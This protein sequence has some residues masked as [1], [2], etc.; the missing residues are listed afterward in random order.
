MAFCEDCQCPREAVT[1][2]I[3]VGET[4]TARRWRFT[5]HNRTATFSRRILVEDLC[6]GSGKLV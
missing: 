4:G 1:T 5:P 6:G 3:P 2:A